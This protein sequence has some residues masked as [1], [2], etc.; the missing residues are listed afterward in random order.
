MGGGEGEQSAAA[1]GKPGEDDRGQQ[2]GEEA[3]KGEV[4]LLVARAEARGAAEYTHV[5]GQEKK[6]RALLSS[7]GGAEYEISQFTCDSC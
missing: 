2:Q 6:K 4:E 7:R 3:E 5:H 1:D